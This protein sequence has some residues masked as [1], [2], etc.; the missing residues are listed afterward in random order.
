MP[1]VDISASL[2]TLELEIVARPSNPDVFEVASALYSSIRPGV[3][4]VIFLLYS[5]KMTWSCCSSVNFSL[6]A[7]F[8]FYVL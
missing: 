1:S 7:S 8:V 3:A 2:D 4:S 5:S 6:L